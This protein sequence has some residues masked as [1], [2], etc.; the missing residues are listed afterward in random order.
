[1]A[2]FTYEDFINSNVAPK[3]AHHIGVYNNDGTKIGIIPL[4]ALTNSQVGEPLYRF[5]LL[6][7]IHVDTTDYNYSQYLNTYPYSDEGEGDFKR[8]LKWLTEK[9]H[10]NMVC[11]CGDLSQ[12][13]TT[14]E[15]SM[16]QTVISEYL[17]ESK[18][19]PFYTCTGNHDVKTAG[20]NGFGNYFLRS[21]EQTWTGMTNFQRSTAFNE[22]FC[23]D[24]VHGNNTDHFIFFSMYSYSLGSSASP[25][26]AADITWLENK[27]RGWKNDRCFVFTHLFFPDYAGNL[28]RINGSGGIYPSGNWLG[29]TQ[30]TQLTDLLSRYKNALWFSGHSHWKWD[31]QKYQDNISV[32]QYSEN[33]AWTVHV[34]SLALPID[35]DYSSTS[36]ETEKSREEKP[37]ESQGAV[38][39]VYDNCIIIRG[40]D[41]NINTSENGDTTHDFT[42]DTY[43]RYLPIAIYN[44]NTSLQLIGNEGE[45]VDPAVLV[46]ADNIKI[47]LGGNR[48]NNANQIISTSEANGN[49]I[50]RVEFVNSNQSC[51]L[52]DASLTS[53]AAAFRVT[54]DNV[55]I[56]IRM[57]EN[58]EYITVPTSEIDNY[59]GWLVS[60]SQP[61]SV[62]SINKSFDYTYNLTEEYSSFKYGEDPSTATDVR[63]VQLNTSS[64]LSNSSNPCWIDNYVTA[65]DR[66]AFANGNDSTF[67]IVVEFTNLRIANVVSLGT[68]DP[69]PDQPDQPTLT[70]QVVPWSTI[71]AMGVND[72]LDVIMANP[73]RNNGYILGHNGTSPVS[74]GTGFTNLDAMKTTAAS[75]ADNDNYHMIITKKQEVT[76]EEVSVD[77]PK[78]FTATGSFTGQS[79]SAL[80]NINAYVAI[81]NYDVYGYGSSRVRLGNNNST[82]TRTG[83]MT[84]TFNGSQFPRTIYMAAYVSNTSRTCT[85]RVGSTTVVNAGVNYS[86][87][88]PSTDLSTWKAYSMT[89]SSITVTVSCSD[90]SN[91]STYANFYVAVPNNIVEQETTTTEVPGDVY[92]TLSSK[93][94]NY[95]PTGTNAAASWSTDLLHYTL[96]NPTSLGSSTD[97]TTGVNANNNGN[98]IRFTNPTNNHLNAGGGLSSLKFAAGTGEWS[99]WYLLQKD[100]SSS[101]SAYLTKSCFESNDNK[102]SLDVNTYV[103]DLPNDYVAVSLA[104]TSEGFWVTPPN[105]DTTKTPTLVV[106]D[107]QVYNGLNTTTGTQITLPSYVGFYNG[108]D[109]SGD[110]R[111]QIANGFL[112][113]QTES[114]SNGRLQFQTSSSYAGGQITIVM[115]VKVNYA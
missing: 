54:Y 22:T 7:D 81:E 114:N 61:D 14:S 108:A 58:D 36:S 6:S 52:T 44:L 62:Y 95:G 80:T 45:V 50:T 16:P 38:V 70:M 71:Q 9:E 96:S 57:L 28:G 3:E 109:Y 11:A 99:V 104:S 15:F 47:N 53:T 63:G 35:S 60:Y 66:T 30:L 106:E 97:L 73:H 41:F 19:V 67:H 40:I 72:T 102:G 37:L 26:L 4:G 90:V 79:T 51:V 82:T 78:T 76:T 84:I 21:F 89:S 87:Y 86:N 88:R 34:P 112:P 25:Y 31:L 23:F 111:Y 12:N 107:L 13:G 24:K 92:Y 29:G 105:M 98:L 46:T 93:R 55:R 2:Q 100:E 5:G 1:M 43:T 91:S 68:V 20:G 32:Q 83:T 69:G 64:K 42:G 75:V 103:Q 56:Q 101:S 27:L 8:A 49:N 18:G 74:S 77:V 115:K 33:G 65:S 110:A 17:P 10:V 48:N 113:S 39:D 85:M 94:G 59:L